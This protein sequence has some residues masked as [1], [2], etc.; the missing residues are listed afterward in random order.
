MTFLALDRVNFLTNSMICIA[1]YIPHEG[2]T[3]RSS[4]AFRLVKGID[5]SISNFT[6]KFPGKKEWKK[7]CI[8][9]HYFSNNLIIFNKKI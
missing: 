8:S 5:D 3:R 7:P 2:V 9:L 1:H 6:F 4:L